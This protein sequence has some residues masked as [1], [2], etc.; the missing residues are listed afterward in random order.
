MIV[1]VSGGKSNITNYAAS[2]RLRMASTGAYRDGGMKP[3]K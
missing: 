2:P 3:V 1:H